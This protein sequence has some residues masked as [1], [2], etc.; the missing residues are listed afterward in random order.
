MPRLVPILAVLAV[1]AAFAAAGPA[2]AQQAAPPAAQPVT[3]Q[4]ASSSGTLTAL[5]GDPEPGSGRPAAQ[6][7]ALTDDAGRTV[8]VDLGRAAE[9]LGGPLA[10]DRKRVTVT[11]TVTAPGRLRAESV[12]VE[13]PAQPAGGAAAPAAVPQALAG[14]QPWVTLLCRFGDSNAQTPENLL[15]FQR[16]LGVGGP[17][18]YPTAA[19]YWQR[20]SNSAINLTGSEISDWRN[21]PAPR[22]AYVTSSGVDLG[23]AAQDCSAVHDA[24]VSFPSFAGINFAFNDVLDCCAWGGGILL[25]RDGVTKVYAATWLPPWGYRNQ[26]VITHEMGHGFGLDHASGAY[27]ATYDSRWTPMSAAFG[28]CSAP[29]LTPEGRSFGCISVQLLAYHKRIKDWITAARTYVAAPKSYKTITIEGTDS[30]PGASGAYQMVQL[31]FTGS[32]TQYYTA[33]SRRFVTGGYDARKGAPGA[34][35]LPGEAVVLH[36]VDTLLGDRRARVVE[37]PDGNTDPND[38]A[39]MWISGETFF[40]WGQQH[41]MRVRGANTG[42]HLVQV[43]RGPSPN[44]NF[45]TARVWTGGSLPGAGTYFATTEAGEPLT[46]CMADGSQYAGTAWYR[47]PAAAT[48]R[49]LTVYATTSYDSVIAVY[50]GSAVDALEFRACN[51]DFGGTVYPRISWVADAATEYFVQVGSKQ[52]IGGALNATIVSNAVPTNDSFGAAA[53]ATSS[54]KFTTQTLNATDEAGEAQPCVGIAKAVWYRYTASSDGYLTVA[55]SGSNYDTAIAVYTGSSPADLAEVACNDD[56]LGT[57]QS[58]AS[59]P[60]LGGTTYYVQ[61]GGF[62]GRQGDLR[63][64]FSSSLSPMQPAA[65]SAATAAPAD[66]TGGPADR[67]R[68][69]GA[70][71]VPPRR[72]L[73]GPDGRAEAPG[74]VTYA[75]EEEAERVL[76]NTAAPN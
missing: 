70:K 33:E 4:R 3:G 13:G 16:L 43:T 25:N 34:G 76:A 15:F 67:R 51:N 24:A 73:A 37:A 18:G 55:T 11:G 50:T 27:D 8:S 68:G 7:F 58:E 64:T 9:R 31:P 17:T 5:W 57:L 20:A 19:H 36:K 21:L 65:T 40:D 49:V 10:L 75:D 61:A 2:G 72:G 32:A 6:L 62:Y 14:A 59:F 39:A 38:A 69:P 35:T 74:V 63:V 41:A 46:G 44:D 42:G 26:G 29:Y 45:A 71:K 60:T 30:P 54:S 48:P 12:A 52:G 28:S 1:V 23:R 56:A 47:V 53:T 66:Q 22:S